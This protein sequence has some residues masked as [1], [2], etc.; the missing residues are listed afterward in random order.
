MRTKIVLLLVLSL[1][2]SCINNNESNSIKYKLIP[3]NTKAL[4]T[5]KNLEKFKSTFENNSYLKSLLSSNLIYKEVFDVLKKLSY[6]K[7]ILI[8]FYKDNIFHYNII[9]EN[10][11]ID[12]IENAFIH[13]FEG[14]TIISSSKNFSQ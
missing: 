14:N 12:R 8:I 13:N 5:I 6:D 11:S 1:S 9:Y 3:K 7:E 2:F 10:M 4:V